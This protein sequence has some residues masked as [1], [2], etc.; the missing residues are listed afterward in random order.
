M[1]GP[2]IA[3]KS[4]NLTAIYCRLSQ[5]DGAYGDSQSIQNQKNFLRNYVMEQGWQIYDIYVDDGYSGT[6]FNRPGFKQM[7]EDIEDGKINI[8]VTKDLSRLGRNYIEM[9]RYTE[10]YFPN[11][12]VRYIAVNDNVD[13]YKEESDDFTPFKNIINEYYAKDASKK[14]RY[15]LTNIMKNG[16]PCKTAVLLYGYLYDEENRRV[17]DPQTAKVVQYIFRRFI[18][19]RDTARIAKELEQQKV[20][21]PLYYNYLTTGYNEK[22]YANP[23]EKQKYGWT[24]QTIYKILKKREYKGDYVRG[25]VKTKFKSNIKRHA[26]EEEL[27]IFEHKYE[28]LVSDEDFDLVQHLL[29]NNINIKASESFNPYRK[30]VKCGICGNPLRIAYDKD[31]NTTRVY[32]RN[33]EGLES[34]AITLELLNKIVKEDILKMQE[35]ILSNEFEFLKRVQAYIDKQPYQKKKDDKRLELEK[36][37]ADLEKTRL[38]EKNV[39]EDYHKKLISRETYLSLLSTYSQA[40]QDLEKKIKLKELEVQNQMCEKVDLYS[41]AQN[42]IKTLKLFDFDLEE[43]YKLISL[44][45]DSIIIKC[46]P[47]IMKY[48][49]RPVIVELNLKGINE[50]VRGYIDGKESRKS[51][52]CNIC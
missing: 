40:I 6:N 27:Y 8:V 10:E 41:E 9:G 30:L 44:L 28:A 50:F 12:N 19:I 52:M 49:K 43:D 13:T 45:Y 5:D 29:Q 47:V 37:I 17:P 25:K 23:T 33:K 24:R 26:T 48:K 22:M 35:Y 7:I 4:Q 16:R 42:F 15:S 36:L 39:F 18:E 34:P 20:F 51:S 1:I 46:E 11:H 2:M 32:C 14:V 3:N 31:T 38:D 21:L